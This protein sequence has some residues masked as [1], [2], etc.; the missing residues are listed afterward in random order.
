MMILRVYTMWN[1]SRTILRVLLFIY[2]VQ[3]ILSVLYAGIYINPNTYLS[4]TITQI[5]DLSNPSFCTP[6]LNV[7]PNLT[8]YFMIPRFVLSVVLLVL[9]LAQTLKQS[10]EM[11]K[12]TEQWQP[13]R[14][15]QLLV[16]DGIIYFFTSL[17][18]NT[19][20]TILSGTGFS[21][22][23]PM[24]I[25]PVCF[26]YVL[27]AT[28]MPRFI[29]SVREAYDRDFRRR[30]WQGGD[31]PFGLLSQSIIGFAVVDSGQDQVG[32]GHSEV[33]LEVLGDVARQA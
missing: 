7:P 11:Y 23:N 22:S 2:L 18:Y 32:E 27:F 21:T 20:E 8:V 29:I 19:T 24:I 16:R 12:A 28:I 13:N 10:V 30:G 33:Q 5:P 4:V 25:V 17:L 9:A 3:T 6:F 15:M 14:Y 1:Q 31:T 26:V